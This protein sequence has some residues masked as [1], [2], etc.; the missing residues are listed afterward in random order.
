VGFGADGALSMAW[1][2]VYEGNMRDIAFTISR[3]NGR[4]F[5]VPIRVSEDRWSIAGC[6]DDGPS[7]AV[8]GQDRVHIVWPTVVEEKG[9]PTKALFHAMSADGRT[10]TPRV[11][12]P[13]EQQANHPQLAI[14]ND[15]SIAAIWDESGDGMRRIVRARG[16]VDPSGLAVF[17]RQAAPAVEMGVYPAVVYASGGRLLEAWTSGAPASSV[18]R[19]RRSE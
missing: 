19:L 9:G 18:I 4:T 10:F 15:G 16:S 1:R 14:A 13:T 17:E 12:L 3:D 7:L 2:H 6:P 8:D 11:R 5:A